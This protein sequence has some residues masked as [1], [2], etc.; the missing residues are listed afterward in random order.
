MAEAL[1]NAKLKECVTAKSSGIE[2]SGIVN[3]DA[4]ALLQKRGYWRDEYHSKAIEQVIDTPF[5]LVITVCDHANETCPNFPKAV[6]KIHIGF[7]DP[8]GKE[9]EEYEKTLKLI[10]DKLL[11]LIKKELC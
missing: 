11:P 2:A 5:D 7:E 10:E 4:K 1:V 9:I 6:K 8:S 3:P